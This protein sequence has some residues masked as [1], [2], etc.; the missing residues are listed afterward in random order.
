MAVFYT[1]P[2]L[3]NSMYRPN[4]Y[5]TSQPSPFPLVRARAFVIVDGLIV[6]ELYKPPAYTVGVAPINYYF[7]FDVAK[8]LQTLSA[9]NPTDISK[10][11]PKFLNAAYDVLCTDCHTDTALIVYYAYR[12]PITNDLVPL[13]TG[14]PP[15]P[16]V[17]TIPL[18]NYSVIGCRQTLDFI[19]M[20]SYA[21]D[22]PTVGGV[23]DRYFL[24]NLP[25]VYPTAATTTTNPIP[26][27][28]TDNL[29][30]TYIP[31]SGTNA[32]RVIIYDNNQVVQGTAGYISV[33]PNLT[34][35]PR[36][37]GVGI[38]QLAVTSFTPPFF[39]IGLPG[40][41]N[42][43]YYSIQA[44][45]L[46]G[47][48]FTLQS[49]KYM[50]QIVDCCANKIRLHWL[51]RLGGVDAYTFTNKKTVFEGTK[52]DQA[53]KPQSFNYSATPPTTTYD[54]GRFK[55]QQIVNKSYELE[56]TF[57]DAFW[58]QWIAELLSSPEVYMETSTGLVAVVI[59]DS[60]I[61]I[62]ET[63]ELVNVTLTIVEANEISVQ[64]N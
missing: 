14:S 58:G 21:I 55:I 15:T 35:T 32:I 46:I 1:P 52:S 62:E 17:D 37:I 63:N 48:S 44:G 16:V 22:Y 19:G 7:E 2:Y 23:Y 47:T 42:G 60:Q 13:T 20:D 25:Y 11:F 5:V 64:Q 3:P 27:C 28:R 30:M 9:P 61:K 49:V 38:P 54:K 40:I 56:S 12:D 59:E 53:Q 31:T 6:T 41:P 50:F 10:P 51:N 24:T 39:P 4:Y 45:N 34:F 29:N 18:G 8:V 33:A 36:S 57:Y 26:I 43:W